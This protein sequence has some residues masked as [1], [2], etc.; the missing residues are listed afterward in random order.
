MATPV[1]LITGALTGIGR[2]TAFAF[3]KN[4]AKLVVSGRHEDAGE[5]LAGE[6]RALDTEA[7]FARADVRH[8]A[9]VEGLVDQAVERFGRLDVAVNNAGT[10][11]RIAPIVEQTPESYADTFD[12]N[13]LGMLLSMKHEFRAMLAQGGGSIVNIT[14]V[15]GEIG[16]TSASVYVGSKHA[17]IGLTRV[18]ALEGA[19]SGIRVNAVAPGF[20]ET[21]MMHRATGTDEVRSAVLEVIPQ[22]RFGRPDDIAAVIVLLASDACAYLTGQVVTVDGGLTAGLP[23]RA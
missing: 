5:A 3:A 17:V 16:L 4:G 14:S 18:A 19:A 20:T 8:E 22:R 11:G 21:A 15:Y 13:V 6:L 12:T 2:S 9:D 23:I 1:V 10:E 7:V